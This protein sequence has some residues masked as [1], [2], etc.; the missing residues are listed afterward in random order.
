MFFLLIFPTIVF[1]KYIVHIDSLNN[2]HQ[3]IK[4]NVLSNQHILIDN[5]HY[6]YF[7]NHNDVYFI[8]KDIILKS[9]AHTECKP[10]WGMDRIN[11]YNL[12]LDNYYYYYTQDTSNIDIYIIDTG[13]DVDHSEFINNKP[14]LLDYFGS[15][16]PNDCNGHGTHVAGIIGGKTVG[17]AKN[18]NLFSIKIDSDCSGTAYCSDMVKAV[19]LAID[20]MKNTNKKSI[21]NL[22]FGVCES[23][24]SKL[25]DFMNLGGIVILSS[26][27]DGEDISNIKEYHMFNTNRGFIVGSTD[28]DDTLSSYSNYG[29]NVYMYAPGSQILSANYIDNMCIKFSGTSMSAPFV[30]AITALYW[31]NRTNEKNSDI[32]FNLK[33]FANKN[34]IISNNVIHNNLIYL[35]YNFKKVIDVYPI[36]FIVFIIFLFSFGFICVIRNKRDKGLEYFLG[37]DRRKEARVFPIN[38]VNNMEIELSCNDEGLEKEDNL[39]IK[40]EAIQNL[41][42]EGKND[43]L[44]NNNNLLQISNNNIDETTPVSFSIIIEESEEKE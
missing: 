44:I 19:S 22:S 23:V 12:P 36:M 16:N 7:K 2:I 38:N 9:H 37:K 14:T 41:P 32:I 35:P 26:G 18:S 6:N 27:N 5:I 15:D 10:S 21:I 31:N 11:Q 28:P 24:T 39:N 25:N 13:I 42:I 1:S 40:A 4:Y 33:E 20:R 29:N 17:L 3:E 34:K 30:T 43:N 8:E